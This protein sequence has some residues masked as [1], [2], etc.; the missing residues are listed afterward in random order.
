MF[1]ICSPDD[2]TIATELQRLINENERGRSIRV[3][4]YGYNLFE[5]LYLGAEVIR[6]LP[7]SDEDIIITNWFS[8]IVDDTVDCQRD[9]DEATK[10]NPGKYLYAY[11]NHFTPD[12]NELIA[13]RLYAAL[14]ANGFYRN[15]SPRKAPQRRTQ[16]SKQWDLPYSDDLST[17]KQRLSAVHTHVF[18]KIGSI[19]VNCNPFT[20]GHRYLIEYAASRVRHL[21]IFAV[22][23]DK[24][25]FPF[26]D[27]FALIKAG[28]SDIENVS[29]LPS[30]KFIISSLTF[31][32]YFNKS[33]IQD[34]IIDP[35]VDVELFGGE[36]APMLGITVRFAGEEPLD[37]VTRQYNE[38]MARILPRYGV[39]FRVIPRRE[40]GGAPISAS[41][42]RELL[43]EQNFDEIAKLVPQTTYEYL[44]AKVRVCGGSGGGC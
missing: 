25:I 23:E 36:I 28:T 35:S 41:R 13:K 43:K 21:F 44:T 12:G 15:L 30:G 40:S 37:N 20:L 18:G 27:R 3:E 42:V 11:R 26:E 31:S 34:Q 33:E 8:P 4:N 22:E 7:V 2:K 19:V 9:F 5:R 10:E 6:N 32:E 24:S 16:K 38:T 29:V 1:G 14:S 17:Y 39:E